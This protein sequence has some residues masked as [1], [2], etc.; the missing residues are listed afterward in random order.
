MREDTCRARRTKEAARWLRP[1][2]LPGVP[3]FLRKR[4]SRVAGGGNGGP[5]LPS[6]FGG[7]LRLLVRPTGWHCWSAPTADA[8]RAASLHRLPK[9]LPVISLTSFSERTASRCSYRKAYQHVFHRL[10]TGDMLSLLLIWWVWISICVGGW[11]LQLKR[12]AGVDVRKIYGSNRWHHCKAMDASV[13][14]SFSVCDL[15]LSFVPY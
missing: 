9:L 12:L 14:F 3:Q 1:S 5:S 13:W 8:A 4:L 10:I 6:T 2:N 7:A 11:V 15:V